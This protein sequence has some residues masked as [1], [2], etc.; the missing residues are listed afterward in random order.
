VTV[1]SDTLVLLRDRVEIDVRRKHKNQQI[2]GPATT[3]VMEAQ[4]VDKESTLTVLSFCI[5]QRD[6]LSW[7][8]PKLHFLTFWRK[9]AR[10]V[11]HKF[12]EEQL[13]EAKRAECDSKEN[14]KNELG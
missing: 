4:C 3:Q 10:R 13:H 11:Y 1:Y 7:K 12:Q 8:P 2:R 5:G 9:L 14:P 6:E